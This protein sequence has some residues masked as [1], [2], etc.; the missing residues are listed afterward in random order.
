VILDSLDP[1]TMLATVRQYPDDRTLAGQGGPREADGDGEAD[2]EGSAA[3]YDPAF[4]LPALCLALE[5]GQVRGA[6]P[7]AP[8]L[9]VRC[10]LL[11]PC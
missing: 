3:V 8:A 5:T 2:G 10:W 11:M 9:Y 6:C 7:V 4:V 1:A